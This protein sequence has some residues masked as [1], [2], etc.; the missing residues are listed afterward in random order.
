MPISLLS[1]L[2]QQNKK[3]TTLT[4][5]YGLDKFKAVSKPP[6]IGETSRVFKNE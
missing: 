4:N 6:Y 5:L 2:L 3:I 1:F